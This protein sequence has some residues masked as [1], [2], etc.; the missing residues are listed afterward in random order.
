MLLQVLSGAWAGVPKHVQHIGDPEAALF[1]LHLDHCT[2][3]H[4]AH[5]PLLL[6]AFFISKVT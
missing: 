5:H 6:S 3:N 2:P 1:H 4:P